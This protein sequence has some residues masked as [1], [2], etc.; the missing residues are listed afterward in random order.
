MKTILIAT[1]LF[2][3][4]G[5][6]TVLV[7]QSDVVVTTPDEQVIYVKATEKGQL[8]YDNWLEGLWGDTS[9]VLI[10][11]DT[12]EYNNLYEKSY[13]SKRRNKRR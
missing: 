1:L 4:T 7:E 6:A 8:V 5:C 11:L 2:I 9:T 10:L 12:V 3:T 13:I